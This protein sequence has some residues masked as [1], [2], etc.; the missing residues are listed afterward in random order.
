MS[1]VNVASAW[2]VPHHQID[3]KMGWGPKVGDKKTNLSLNLKPYCWS[4]LSKKKK[5]KFEVF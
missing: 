2:N 3:P 5:T 1:C 4:F